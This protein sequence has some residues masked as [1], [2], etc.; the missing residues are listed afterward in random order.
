M[1]FLELAFAVGCLDCGLVVEMVP[2][3]EPSHRGDER[4]RDQPDLGEPPGMGERERGI[5]RDQPSGNGPD[6]VENIP[7]VSA[8][9]AIATNQ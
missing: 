9:T 3:Q 2:D 1:R 4:P 7:M 5:A 6:H 8:P